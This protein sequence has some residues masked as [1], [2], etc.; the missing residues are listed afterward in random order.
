MFERVKK[1]VK[2]KLDTG[3]E[4][5]LYFMIDGIGGFVWRME[6]DLADGRIESTPGIEEDLLTMR[7]TQQYATTQL[8][9]VGVEGALDEN[10]RPTDVYWKWYKTW[11]KYIKGLSDE[12]FYKLDKLSQDGT[13]SELDYMR[14]DPKE[15]NRFD[16]IDLD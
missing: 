16:L 2:E 5:L 4:H 7:E 15:M 14:P 1:E 12:D 9:R 10:L 6:H 8:S 3:C 13:D 11:D